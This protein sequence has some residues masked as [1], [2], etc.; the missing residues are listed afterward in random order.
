MTLPTG[1][2][3]RSQNLAIWEGMLAILFINWSTGVV[4]TGYAL[5]LGAPPAAL[6]IL[7]ALPMV[8]QM[9]A[10]LA[11]FFRGNRKD[12]SA[13]LSVFGRGLFVLVLFVPLM[14][15]PW[16][17]HGLLLIAALSQLVVVMDGLDG[18]PGARKTAGALFRFT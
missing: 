13:N 10:P 2:P 17:I 6:A 14:P 3:R 5:W 16:R 9:A 12:W 11:L 4:M 7:G 15:E 1:E 8:G 18:R